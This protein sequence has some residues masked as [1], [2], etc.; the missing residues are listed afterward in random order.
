[1]HDTLSQALRAVAAA[2]KYRQR[3]R[4]HTL[5]AM[6][7]GCSAEGPSRCNAMRDR[8]TECCRLAVQKYFC[9]SWLGRADSVT[10]PTEM[11]EKRASVLG[12]AVWFTCTSIT[13]AQLM[14]ISI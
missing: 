9:Q 5:T 1:M 4:Q 12:I 11:S 6:S 7:I 8:S 14:Y 2:L 3:E 10:V 13:A